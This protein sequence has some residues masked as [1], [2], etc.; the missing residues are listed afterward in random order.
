MSKMACFDLRVGHSPLVRG[1]I[2]CSCH[3]PIGEK[4]NQNICARKCYSFVFKDN[5]MTISF[6][7]VHF[8][9]LIQTQGVA[10]SLQGD[11]STHL[12]ILKNKALI[13]YPPA[14]RVFLVVYK[15]FAYGGNPGISPSKVK[16]CPPPP[17]F[18]EIFNTVPSKRLCVC[19]IV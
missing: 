15:L 4:K 8:I 16:L 6:A 19:L 14:V 11:A 2:I 3:M 9:L 5:I 17:P 7:S 1:E 18:P 10:K 13:I 12:T